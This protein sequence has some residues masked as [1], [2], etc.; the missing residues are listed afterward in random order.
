M[1]LKSVLNA[2]RIKLCAIFKGIN[3]EGLRLT[4]YGTGSKAEVMQAIEQERRQH[5]ERADG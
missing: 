3:S 5:K 1:K 2:V 4:F